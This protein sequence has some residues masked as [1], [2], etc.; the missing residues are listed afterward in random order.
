[1]MSHPRCRSYYTSLINSCHIA[2]Y[3]NLIHE[4][5]DES[6]LAELLSNTLQRMTH[7][8]RGSDEWRREQHVCGNILHLLSS[9]LY[10]TNS[11]DWNTS[12]LNGIVTIVENQWVEILKTMTKLL[13]SKEETHSSYTCPQS[14]TWCIVFIR[15]FLIATQNHCSQQNLIVS[16]GLMNYR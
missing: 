11:A 3:E 9:L 15:Q 13:L 4:L 14:L 6:M 2:S 1:M 16:F 8:E 7:G 5:D 12:R 10:Y